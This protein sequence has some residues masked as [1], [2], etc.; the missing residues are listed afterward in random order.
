MMRLERYGIRLETMTSDHL[1]MIRLWRNQDHVRTR[2]QFQGLLSSEDQQQ[3]YHSLDPLTNMY[4]VIR[5]RGYPI[6][7]VHIKDMDAQMTM[8]EAGAFIGEPSYLETPQAMLAIIFM[9]EIGFLTLGLSR[10]RAKI[11]EDNSRAIRF[12]QQLGY[13]LMPDQ[14]SGF[15]YYETSEERF[16]EKTADIRQQAA[17]LYGAQSHFEVD[18]NSVWRQR[19][20]QLSASAESYFSPVVS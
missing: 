6:G 14:S 2:M 15:R 18:F 10:L 5:Y 20:T 4:W 17:R 1:E 3:W 9:M 7:L 8:G 11:H 16:F 19:F 12:N 13:R